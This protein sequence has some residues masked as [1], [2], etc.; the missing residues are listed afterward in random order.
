[1]LFEV[2]INHRGDALRERA[3]RRIT[4]RGGGHLLQ[5][6]AA[7]QQGRGHG[8]LQAEQRCFHRLR[9]TLGF[10][11]RTHHVIGA[12]GNA[13]FDR[14][15]IRC[16]Q[17]FIA[18]QLQHRINRKVREKT[19]GIKLDADVGQFIAHA[20]IIEEQRR[21]VAVVV[22]RLEVTELALQ[23]TLRPDQ[24]AFGKDH[25]LHRGL[26]GK[27]LQHAHQHRTFNRHLQIAGDLPVG[28]T[29]RGD[30][31]IGVELEQL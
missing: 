29:K 13:H 17:P 30:G 6:K 11:R 9:L 10:S 12:L 25:R 18:H 14:L 4:D 3:C 28:K 5:T 26:R 20:K 19:A 22:I 7:V 21:A 23:H 24:P 1:M 27:A 8:V 31:L 2:S 15:D 16:A